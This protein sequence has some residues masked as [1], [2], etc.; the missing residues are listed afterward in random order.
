[1]KEQKQGLLII[2]CVL[3]LITV[4]GTTC[5][6]FYKCFSFFFPLQTEESN[7]TI[8]QEVSSPDNNWKAVMFM[9]N[10]GATTPFSYEVSLMK[11]EES[12]G[13]KIGNIWIADT[14]GKMGEVQYEVRWEDK[15]TLLITIYGTPRIFKKEEKYKEI[16]IRYHYIQSQHL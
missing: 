4:L 12:L 16:T 15:K 5:V 9:R 3:S 6:Y 10:G 13:N 1:M 7:N 14:G 8:I 11:K 2:L